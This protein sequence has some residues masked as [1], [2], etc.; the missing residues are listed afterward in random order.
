MSRS[1][2]RLAI[3]L[4]AI[5]SLLFSQLAGSA[6]VCPPGME[7]AAMVAPAK[8]CHGMD[9]AQPAL[10]HQ[11]ASGTAQSFE[12]VKLPTPSLPAIVQ[13]VELPRIAPAAVA[14]HAR[15]AAPPE[16]RPPREPVFLAT[17]RLRV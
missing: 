7:R 6:Y 14:M 17:L 13:V 10:C 15:R 3:C 1:A 5:A 16:L 11:H 12:A 8:P 9:D 4:W 2:R